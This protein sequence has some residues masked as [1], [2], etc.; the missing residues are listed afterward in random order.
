MGKYKMVKSGEVKIESL[1]KRNFSREFMKK[2]YDVY[3]DDCMSIVEKTIRFDK[4]F[5]DEF[6]GRK[7]YRRIGEGTNRFVCLL[8][9]HVIK[10]AYNYLA[11]IDNMNELA[12]AKKFPEELAQAYETNGLIL[13]SEYVTVMDK[14]DF[15]ESQMNIQLILTKLQNEVSILGKDKANYYILGDMGVSNKNY[16]N[17]G[18][19]INGDIVVLDYGY[20][21]EMPFN[22]WKEIAKCPV[23][24]ASLEYTDD[25]TE[26][27]CIGDQ[28][29]CKVKY[30]SLR[31]NLGYAKI[32][33]N[34]K[35][36]LNNDKYIKFNKDGF[37][38]VDVM[39]RVE[40]E[41]KKVEEFKMPEEYQVKLDATMSRFFD[42][43]TYIKRKG[44]LSIM[45]KTELKEELYNEINNY[46]E[47]LFPMLIA[48]VEL[49]D[50][51]IESFLNDFNK[52]F[53]E[54]YN[55][56]YN[57]LQ[58]IN[59]IHD[60]KEDLDNIE[61]IYEDE[62]ANGY[63]VNNHVT[64]VDR[65]SDKE[66][67]KKILTSL[68][69]MLSSELGGLSFGDLFMADDNADILDKVE[70]EDDHYSLDE[71]LN[72]ISNEMAD[73]DEPE[74][75]EVEEDNIEYLL[76]ERYNNLHR[77]LTNML[78][79]IAE[80][81]GEIDYIEGEVY[82]TYLNGD[83]ID[84]E[85]R[86]E[87]NASNILGGWEP[88]K[89][90]F[91]LYR[92]MLVMF[93][94]DTDEVN[95]EFEARYRIDQD[96]SL[97]EDIYDRLENRNIVMDQILNRFE[98]NKP[99]KHV[100]INSIARE[101]D[102]YYEALDKY[103]ENVKAESRDVDIDDPKYYF[104]V[105]KTNT[106]I[107]K[108]MDEAKENLSDELYD[109]GLKLKDMLNEYKIVYYYDVEYLYN[110]LQDDL[111]NVIKN[112]RLI[113]RKGNV[114]DNVKDLII[115]KYF[116]TTRNI[117]DDSS[118]ECFVYGPSFV[119]DVGNELYKR[120][121][122]PVLKA[123][124]VDKDST[125]DVYKPKVFN[126][127]YYTRIIIEQRYETIFKDNSD[128][129]S[130]LNDLI[131]SLNS[132]DLY[133]HKSNISKYNMKTSKDNLRYLLTEKEVDLLNQ[134]QEMYGYTS[135]KDKT[136]AFALAIV[137][138]LNKEY[139]ISVESNKFLNNLATKGLS[140]AL[141]ERSFIINILE[142]NG[143]MTRLDYLNR[144]Q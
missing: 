12:M 23:C 129:K 46:D 29:T 42:I 33:D 5:T 27:H 109:K 7:D 95:D 61:D 114:V 68:D 40:V 36:N 116:E 97:P 50:K 94:Y 55:R 41:E 144:I 26:L 96:V 139:D 142:I 11:Y 34:I 51:N 8:D 21:Y 70:E 135:I 25:Y 87:V 128:E 130:K 44:F 138:M 80:G 134:Y 103:Y 79:N 75:E 115:N 58:K 143:V 53:K 73:K 24:G 59:E 9:N 65:L 19:R 124:L 66:G 131:L 64:F 43:S 69:D 106:E 71:I 117:I 85:Y 83:C 81:L 45:T 62:E 31:N 60:I 30:T 88:D 91:P 100:L 54:R 77:A 102:L 86:P 67:G 104:E 2:I 76:Q 14:E 98:T 125:E 120:T 136:K 74:T 72:I 127:D 141:A 15:L 107:M 118:L 123:K 112:L 32:I 17:W 13:V 137:E 6:G 37:I 39:E 111:T 113:D 84:W 22:T 110:S 49:D 89:F 126:K 92:H 93:D 52:K 121:R 56:L 47:E 133:Y 122:K 140:E 4:L 82:G 99:R 108:E 57:D 119:L 20:L 101:L 48:V 35:T 132:K 105:V 63:N 90:A 16:G 78:T 3:I 28:C 10:V 18:R 38:N 1:I